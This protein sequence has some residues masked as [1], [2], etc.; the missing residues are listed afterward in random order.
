M[1]DKF[2]LKNL[3]TQTKIAGLALLISLFALISVTV[4][5]YIMVKQAAPDNR[6]GL[7]FFCIFT[8]VLIIVTVLSLT[9]SRLI[10]RPISRLTVEVGK[11]NEE[12]LQ[13]RIPVES[14]DEIGVLTM[15]FNKMADNLYMYTQ[16]IIELVHTKNELESA[17]Y[18][19][20]LTGL[21][22]RRYYM[23]FSLIHLN[24]AFRQN[25]Y[26]F[27]IMIDVDHFK[28]VNDTYGHQVG[29]EVL[30]QIA[31]RIKDTVRSYDLLARYGGEEFVLLITDVGVG[32]ARDL[33][34]RIRFNICSSPIMVEKI[35]ITISASFGMVQISSADDLDA[36]I[37][38][39]D[40]AMYRA[41]NEGRNRTVFFSEDKG[42][43]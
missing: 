40:K 37:A 20:T 26:A 23:E 8:V 38:L 24:R 29:D 22:N 43:Q 25:G 32:D 19:D 14:A 31:R 33:V 7:I 1:K 2:L 11:I 13:Y 42:W 15:A 21:F 16:H 3:K 41:K 28:R 4:A 5:S 30:K 18:I 34:E 35:P 10:S 27:F 9:L 39:A 6:V 12:N 36:A 17:A